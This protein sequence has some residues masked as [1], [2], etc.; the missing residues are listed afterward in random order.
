M[1]TKMPFVAQETRIAVSGIRSRR[2]FALAVVLLSALILLIR[3]L[4]PVPGL[5]LM[6]LIAEWAAPGF[7]LWGTAGLLFPRII[8]DPAEDVDKLQ[9]GRS[10]DPV[11]NAFLLVVVEQ[12]PQL[13]HQGRLLVFLRQI[14]GH[15]VLAD[16]GQ[17]FV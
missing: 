12:I 9:D 13:A 14:L 8:F 1:T 3:G 15:E 11:P 2:W 16:V 6:R 5:R 10:L 17:A 4:V 7:I